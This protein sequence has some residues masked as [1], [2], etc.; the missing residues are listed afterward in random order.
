MLL[1][2]LEPEHLSSLSLREV[3]SAFTVVHSPYASDIK[4]NITFSGKP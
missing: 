1:L 2:I 3:L 4:L